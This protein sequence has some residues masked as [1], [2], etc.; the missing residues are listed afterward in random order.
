[1]L[2]RRR[3]F[4]ARTTTTRTFASTARHAVAAR[5]PPRQNRR[6]EGLL[7]QTMTAVGRPTTIARVARHGRL[8]AATHERTTTIVFTA[9]TGPPRVAANG[10][11]SNRDSRP[12]STI[13]VFL[14]NKQSR[15][16]I[17]V[18]P[19]RR[20]ARRFFF[21]AVRTLEDELRKSDRG[22]AVDNWTRP[23]TFRE[24]YRVR[25]FKT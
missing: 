20:P 24:E 9:A 25:R 15:R 17:Q 18:S 3:R 2:Q 14:F 8:A 11:Q 12:I 13:R 7:D 6:K 22:A 10:E 1:M 5:F 16:A 4:R 21:I 19:E 23:T